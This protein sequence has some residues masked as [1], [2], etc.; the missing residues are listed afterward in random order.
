MTS[1]QVGHDVYV[2]AGVEQNGHV[3]VKGGMSDFVSGHAVGP[4]H[5]YSAGTP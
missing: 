5:F 2:T 3:M 1:R 4:V